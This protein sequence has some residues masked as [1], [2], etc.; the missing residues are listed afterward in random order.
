MFFSHDQRDEVHSEFP[1]HSFGEIPEIL[2]Q[3]FAALYDEGRVPYV[4][5]VIADK[6]RY[7]EVEEMKLQD[8]PEK[9]WVHKLAYERLNP[10][11]ES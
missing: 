8:L 1:I 2:Q 10:S 7:S 11:T 6:R 9:I 4:A 5:L 3:K